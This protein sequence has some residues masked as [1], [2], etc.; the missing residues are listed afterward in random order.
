[1][2]KMLCLNMIVRNETANLARCLGALADHIDCWVIGDT[3]STD[4]TQDFIKSFFAARQKPGELHS[5]PFENFEQARNAALDCAFASHLAYDYLLLADADMELVVEDKNF[6]DRLEGPGYRL[7]QR[8]DSGLAYWNTRL[9][10]RKAGARYHGVTHEYLD[11]PAGVKEFAGVWYKDH[12]S[13]SNRV[14]KF[15]RDIKLLL[16]ALEREPEKEKHRYWFY[17]AQSYR[18]AGPTPEAA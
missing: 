6:R 12:A 18:D 7:L 15:E 2:T 3:G 14:D 10:A 17:L 16:E 13:G 8:A 9:V 11:V 1:M 4:G 5:F